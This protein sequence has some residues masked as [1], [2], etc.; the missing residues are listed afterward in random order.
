MNNGLLFVKNEN[1]FY[2]CA[3]VLFAS[4]FTVYSPP[5]RGY[6]QSTPRRPARFGAGL[7]IL[8]YY[9]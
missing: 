3:A 1:Y 4:A 8:L 2:L 5:S 9:P 6:L 7:F